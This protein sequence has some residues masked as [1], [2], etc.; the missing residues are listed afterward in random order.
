MCV[1]AHKSQAGIVYIINYFDILYWNA[2]PCILIG[3]PIHL[4]IK[5]NTKALPKDIH[6]FITAIPIAPL[7]GMYL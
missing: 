6:D 2:T 5:P 1:I 4:D 7:C 3:H